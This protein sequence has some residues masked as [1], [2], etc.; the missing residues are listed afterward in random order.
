MVGLY[1]DPHGEKVFQKTTS[2][3]VDTQLG[4]TKVNTDSADT[5]YLRKRVRELETMVAN[6]QVFSIENRN[7]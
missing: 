4:N 7:P 5:E 6:Q 3:S 1:K 2:K